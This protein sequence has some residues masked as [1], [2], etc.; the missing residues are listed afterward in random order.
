MDQLPP[1]VR[2]QAVQLQEAEQRAQALATQRQQLQTNLNETEE[3]LKELDK[4]DEETTLYKS[5]GGVLVKSD[6]SEAVKE[7]EER[8]ETLN[9]RIET[10]KKQ[11]EKVRSQLEQMRAKIQTAL[12][13]QQ[14]GGAG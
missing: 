3:A 13:G 9:I 12:Q 6:R 5:V 11:E 4:R 10:V 8:K 14:F 1:Q 2:Q 7:L